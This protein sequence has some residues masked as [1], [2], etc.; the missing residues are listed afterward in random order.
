MAHP[1]AKLSLAGANPVPVYLERKLLDHVQHAN[2]VCI[3][4]SWPGNCTHPRQLKVCW[5]GRQVGFGHSSVQVV[6]NI[7]KRKKHQQEIVD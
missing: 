3:V 4:D 5:D 1:I 2:S 6:C 7:S